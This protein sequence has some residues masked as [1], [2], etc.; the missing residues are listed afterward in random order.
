MDGNSKDGKTAKSKH[1]R[2]PEK[3]QTKKGKK[4]AEN[5]SSVKK[6]CR[7]CRNQQQCDNNGNIITCWA[8]KQILKQN[9]GIIYRNVSSIIASNSSNNANL[10]FTIP[11]KNR[12]EEWLHQVGIAAKSSNG[13]LDTGAEISCISKRFF[14]KI[15]KSNDYIVENTDIV[16]N[17]PFRSIQ[18]YRPEGIVYDIEINLY[19]EL[20][21]RQELITLKEVIIIDS[22]FDLI[23]DRESI[24]I[25]NLLHKCEKQILKQSKGVRAVK[26][27]EVMP[28]MFLLLKTLLTS[29]HVMLIT[30]S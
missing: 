18:T 16:I 19:N 6:H 2:T 20:S 3:E 1:K 27:D 13:L 9:K 10:T 24:S 8:E 12:E 5:K 4:K 30:N 28:Q 26:T 29:R 11:L 17:T 7:V 23:V 21:K 25:N 15:K 22:A 14:N